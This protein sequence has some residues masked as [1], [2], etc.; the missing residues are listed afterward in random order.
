MTVLADAWAKFDRANQHARSFVEHAAAQA[1]SRPYMITVD[2][3]PETGWHI[4]RAVRTGQ[5]LVQLPLIAGD[6]FTNYR[7]TLDYIAYQMFLVSGNPP[8][9]KRADRVYYPITTKPEDWPSQ[10]NRFLNGITDD[11][12]ATVKETQPCFR[13]DPGGSALADLAFFSR[14][15][16]HKHLTIMGTLT[17]AQVHVTLHTPGGGPGLVDL[18]Q[19]VTTVPRPIDNAELMRWR[20]TRNGVPQTMAMLFGPHPDVYAEYNVAFDISLSHGDRV[21]CHFSEIGEEVRRILELFEP[22]LP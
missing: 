4:C 18:E 8:T 19:V 15:D 10:R 11:F 6:L 17:A 2:D 5:P 16:K 3:E 20:I 12:A 22:L 9:D 14:P 1:Q 21:C 7:T 13:N